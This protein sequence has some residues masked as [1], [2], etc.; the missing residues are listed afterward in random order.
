MTIRVDGH[1]AE[2]LARASGPVGLTGPDG[3]PLGTFT[4]YDPSTDPD[5]QPT[6]SDAEFDRRLT[7]PNTKWHTAAEVETRLRGQS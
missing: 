3:L 2:E 4:P 1:A 6:I 7:D 5:A